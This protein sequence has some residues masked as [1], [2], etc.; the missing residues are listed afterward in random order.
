MAYRD[1]KDLNRN[2]AADKALHNKA[3]NTAK[4]PKYDGYQRGLA[5]MVYK[6][7]DNKISHSGIKKENIPDK[8][9]VEELHKLIIRNFN[10]RKL[11]SPFIDNIWVEYLADMQLISKLNKGSRFLL[12]VSNIYSKYAWVI[13]LKD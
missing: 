7:F 13:P 2:T 11:H 10:K 4:S 9:L 5:S 1:F 3:F 6:L 12:C 8:E